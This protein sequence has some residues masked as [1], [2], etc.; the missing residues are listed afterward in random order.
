MK[1]IIVV[2]AALMMGAYSLEAQDVA[3][4]KTTPHKK[5]LIHPMK[6]LRKL[7]GTV[8]AEK[9]KQAFARD[10]PGMSAISWNRGTNFDEVVFL[11]S[12]KRS[13]AYYDEDAELVGTTV[14]VNFSDLPAKGQ[15]YINKHYP[16]YEKVAVVLFDDNELNETDMVLYNQQFEDEDNYFI[17]LK[18]DN[19]AIVVKCTM[20]GMVSYFRDLK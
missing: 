2:F 7:E 6:K 8:V 19:K 14:A 3:V 10:F 15:Q 17:E 16:G 18:K 12:G 1:A 20:G 13:T 4:N 5:S 11:K 9:S